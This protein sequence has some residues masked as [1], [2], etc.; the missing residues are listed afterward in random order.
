ML[1][2]VF[3]SLFFFLPDVFDTHSITFPLLL[4][5]PF[6]LLLLNIYIVSQTDLSG[7]AGGAAY[8]NEITLIAADP[9]LYG[10]DVS[11]PYNPKLKWLC[12]MGDNGTGWNVVIH[13]SS[14][15]SC[16]AYVSDYS[17]GLQIV[18]FCNDDENGDDDSDD[19]NFQ[20]EV[21]AHFGTG[22]IQTC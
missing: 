2:A 18:K 21:V 15:S 10:Y 4:S 22:E 13:Q 5:L 16:Y 6:P 3:S 14:S 19:E 20:P 9:G 17:G 11:D 1:L 7:W 12:S 8:H